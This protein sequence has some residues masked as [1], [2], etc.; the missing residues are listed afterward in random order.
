MSIQKNLDNKLYL[1][2]VSDEEKYISHT[3][4]KYLFYFTENLE[5]VVGEG[6]NTMPCSDTVKPP[7]ERYIAKLGILSTKK[8]YLDVLADSDYNTYL[9]GVDRIHA[10]AWESVGNNRMSFLFGESLIEVE[11]K[12]AAREIYF[13]YQ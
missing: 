6:W 13:E 12:L 11:S 2:F 8:I 4:H 10:L 3:S 7:H 5:D 9:D 1:C